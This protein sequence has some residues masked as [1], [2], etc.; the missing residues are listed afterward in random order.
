MPDCYEAP[1]LDLATAALVSRVL[2]DMR[3]R[4]HV[5]AIQ[6]AEFVLV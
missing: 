6:G 4:R 1:N 3:V 2:A 5:L